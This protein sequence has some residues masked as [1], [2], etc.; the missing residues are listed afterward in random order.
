MAA[1]WY[2]ARGGQER[3]GPLTS[4]Q[5]RQMAANGQVSGNDLVWKE[6]MPNWV[7][8]SQVKGLLGGSGPSQAFATQ[9]AP[10]P[11]DYPEVTEAV[12]PTGP[13]D[14]GAED[15]GRRE[16]GE[17]WFYGFLERFAKI[18]MWV[19]LALVLLVFIYGIIQAVRAFD[20]SALLGV[21]LLLVTF[22]G[23]AIYVLFILIWT[24]MTL[25]IV[26]AGR[27]LRSINRKVGKT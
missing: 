20:F 16:V 17:P 22:L 10:A 3:V 18:F 19:G 24:A 7:P 14:Y 13:A 11:A 12:E 15:R 4:Q 5:L 26:D 23:S 1:D 9:Q 6:G 27:S 21:L 8:A 2:L 25:L